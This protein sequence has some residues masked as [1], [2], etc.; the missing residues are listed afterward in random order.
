MQ[1]HIYILAMMVLCIGATPAELDSRR[2]S[3]KKFV[4]VTSANKFCMILPQQTKTFCSPDVR[5]SRQHGELPAHFWAFSVFKK[6]KSA[7]GHRFAQITG[8]INS[9]LQPPFD[10]LNSVAPDV[11]FD[12]DGG[13]HPAKSI[14]LGYKNYVQ[15]FNPGNNGQA[16]IKCC[17]DPNGCSSS[18]DPNQQSNCNAVVPGSYC[19]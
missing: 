13:G 11:R 4:S 15:I 12:S 19:S 6:G 5:T 16:C 17:D 9:G 3:G 1:M 2:K 18:T 14:C 7:Q 10:S 8:C